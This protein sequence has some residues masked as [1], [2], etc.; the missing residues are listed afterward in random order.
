M[1]V[2]KA[3]MRGLCS[4]VSNVT[5]VTPCPRAISTAT[6]TRS[7]PSTGAGRL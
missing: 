3:I 1:V 2:K 4:V 7:P 6:A 5:S